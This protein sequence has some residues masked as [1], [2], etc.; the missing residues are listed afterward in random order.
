MKY[1]IKLLVLVLVLGAAPAFGA[2]GGG[3]ILTNEKLKELLTA[4]ITDEVILDK[5]KTSVT[6]F[7]AS[8]KELVDLKKKGASDAILKVVIQHAETYMKDI[9]KKLMQLIS[10]LNDP[11]PEVRARVLLR[12]KTFGEV[13]VPT[14]VDQLSSKSGRVRAGIIEALGDIESK[15]CVNPIFQH[16]TDP[17]LDVREAAA[18]AIAKVADAKMAERLERR[19]QFKESRIDGAI[20][21]LGYLGRK[22]IAPALMKLLA[23]S[24]QV[25]TRRAC[26]RTLGELEA[27]EALDNLINILGLDTDRTVRAA[28]AGALAKLRDE[29]A[30]LM[31]LKAYERYRDNRVDI[32]KNLK[33]FKTEA[34]FAF[35]IAQMNDK[36]VSLEIRALCAASLREMA[37]KNFGFDTKIELKRARAV[38]DWNNWWESN[39]F[40]YSTKD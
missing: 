17:A 29:K 1:G 13:A 7:D 20:I 25:D 38:R 5:V 11:N 30:V 9:K 35:L 19:L 23:T 33:V 2:S 36:E 3:E 39:R 15:E 27:K 21:A 31:F 12:I 14:L 22:K 8:V 4:K 16:L 28:A 34:V 40:R 10:M 24:T 37:G 32:V 18:R 6:K 26:V